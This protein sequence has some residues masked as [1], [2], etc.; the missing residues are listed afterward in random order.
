GEVYAVARPPASTTTRT[1]AHS[2]DER[3]SGRWRHRRWHIRVPA[4]VPTGPQGRTVAPPESNAPPLYAAY[5]RRWLADKTARLG[6]GTAYDWRRI[7]ES[8]LIPV[9]GERGVSDIDVEAVE[10]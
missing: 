6:A 7:V 2:C 4:M 5:V 10:G 3:S 9:F 1:T 8:R